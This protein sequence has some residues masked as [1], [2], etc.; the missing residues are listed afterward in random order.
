MCGIVGIFNLDRAPVPPLLLQRMTRTLA[1]R[2]PDGEGFYIDGSL[3]LGHR[4]L[5]II[6]LSPA[7]AQPM[8]TE[9]EALTVVFNGEIYNFLELRRQLEAIGY[10]FRSKSD[11]EVLLYAYDAWGGDCLRRLNG[12]FAFALWDKRKRELV[13]ARDRY[14]IKPLY[15]YLQGDCLLFASEQKAFLK[16]PSFSPELDP[17][18]LLEY[19]TFQNFFTDRTLLKGVRLFPA[20]CLGRVSLEDRTR[21]MKIERYWDYCFCEP[22]KPQ[23]EAEYIEELERLFVQAVSRQLISDVDVGS[24]LSGGMDSGSITAIAAGQLPW[25]RTFTCGFDLNSASGLELGFDEREKAEYM[26]Y[27]FKTE[28][29]EMVLKADLPPIMIP[30]E[31]RVSGLNESF[32]PQL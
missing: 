9:D 21:G 8:S 5:A 1:H 18:A 10:A 24:Y 12:M 31:M 3:A 4:R 29:Y 32:R 16:H 25:M 28:H 30:P 22:E 26:S 13:M 14:G 11:T 27:L 2:G 15:Y 7:A 17:E 23:R 20:G 6:D 19:F